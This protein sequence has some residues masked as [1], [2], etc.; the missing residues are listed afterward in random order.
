MLGASLTLRSSRGE[1]RLS[2]PE[3]FQGVRKTALAAGEIITDISFPLPGEMARSAFI[4]AGLRRAQAISLANVAV[5]LD[6]AEGVV[7]DARIAFGSVAPTIVRATAAEAMLIGH[8]LTLPRIVMATALVQEAIRPIDDVRAS[9]VYR[10][11]L[12]AVIARRA[13][14]QVAKGEQGEAPSSGR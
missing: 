6:F 7:S 1:R 8:P 3:F 12:A 9:A 13:L 10:R 14:Q 4:K 5:F 2:L 11:H